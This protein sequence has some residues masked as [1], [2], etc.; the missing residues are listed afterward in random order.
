M[1]KVEVQSYCQNCP[2]FEAEVNGEPHETLKTAWSPHDLICNL[3]EHNTT[4]R[5]A[6]RTICAYVASVI[7]HS[8]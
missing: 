1:I 7:T 6:N 2:F 4:I 3:P 5:C 8:L